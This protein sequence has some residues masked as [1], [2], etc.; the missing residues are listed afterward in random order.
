MGSVH[1]SPVSDPPLLSSEHSRRALDLFFQ[2]YMMGFLQTRREPYDLNMDAMQH[3][4]RELAEAGVGT[5]PALRLLKWEPKGEAAS[6]E[7]LQ[8]IDQ[9]NDSLAHSPHPKGEWPRVRE[10][11]GDELL[12]D[13]LGTSQSSLRRYVAGERETPDDVAW[14]LH[15]TARVI[16]DLLGSYNDYGVRRWFERPRSQLDGLAPRDLLRR[17]RT[18][19][20]ADDS[21]V[22]PVLDLAASLAAGQV[23][24]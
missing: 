13:V 7:L 16:S 11:L 12:G 4:A 6:A 2:A 14:L 20:G 10:I 1:F 22:Q 23:A 24:A 17:A 3:I 21:T 8:L 5:E 19:A 9:L 15:A 18:E